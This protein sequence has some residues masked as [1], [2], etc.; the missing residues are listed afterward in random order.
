MEGR[1]FK[2]GF[3]GLAIA[4]AIYAVASVKPEP[5]GAHWD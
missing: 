2:P 4:A 5:S 1:I 3:G